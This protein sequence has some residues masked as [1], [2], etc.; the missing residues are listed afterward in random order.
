MTPPALPRV[1]IRPSEASV[2]AA[3]EYHRLGRC[4]LKIVDWAVAHTPLNSC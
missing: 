2:H 1:R 3:K 4:V